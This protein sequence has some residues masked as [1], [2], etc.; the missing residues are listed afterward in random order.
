LKQQKQQKQQKPRKNAKNKDTRAT[1]SLPKHT[2]FVN[3]SNVTRA[4]V[5]AEFN[6]VTEKLREKG[7][8]RS[9]IR[10]NVTCKPP[11]E[12]TKLL[13]DLLEFRLPIEAE[14]RD[15]EGLGIPQFAPETKTPYYGRIK[16][17]TILE[18]SCSDWT[19][20]TMNSSTSNAGTYYFEVNLLTPTPAWLP[21]Y[22]GPQEIDPTLDPEFPSPRS[23]SVGDLIDRSKCYYGKN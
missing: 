21:E 9:I 6:Y 8:S 10:D 16:Y 17:G 5:E 2:N 7:S 14:R 15:A 13:H 19:I 1:N 4:D 20:A 12:M 22:S 3:T 11:C 23:F 18:G